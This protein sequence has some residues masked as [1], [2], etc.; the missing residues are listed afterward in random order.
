MAYVLFVLIGQK[1]PVHHSYH[2]CAHNKLIMYYFDG[3]LSLYN[4]AYF[5]QH[6]CM[7]R[8]M[9]IHLSEMIENEEHFLQKYNN[10]KNL[11]FILCAGLLLAF[12]SMQMEL[13]G[14]LKI[15]TYCYQKSVHLNQSKI[16]CMFSLLNLAL[17]SLF[18]H[19]QK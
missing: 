15:S 5:E 3:E 19:Q 6:F 8:A 17:I 12:V 10:L 18:V 4:E 2:C 7:R 13:L 16:F 1:S 11:V 9:F 14:I